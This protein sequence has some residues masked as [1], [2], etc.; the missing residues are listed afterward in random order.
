MDYAVGTILYIENFRF[1][2]G[3]GVRNKYF[4]ILSNLDNK[5]IVAS[6][7]TSQDYIPPY[8]QIVHGCINNDPDQINCYKF[9]SGREVCENGFSFEKDTYMHGSQIEIYELSSI[10][11][12]ENISFVGKL[13]ETE[14]RRI[15]KC[16][17]RS[18]SVKKKIIR[19]LERLV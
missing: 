8:R 17:T 14:M 16:F 9:S 2:D 3:G 13:F 5:T 7:P 12:H 18:S 10:R 6:L 19:I 11:N 1:K 15:Y 4:L